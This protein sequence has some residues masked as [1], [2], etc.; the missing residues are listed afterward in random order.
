MESVNAERWKD[1]PSSLL[2]K[3][4]QMLTFHPLQNSEPISVGCILVKNPQSFSRS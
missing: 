3:A 2:Q 1:T 4:P